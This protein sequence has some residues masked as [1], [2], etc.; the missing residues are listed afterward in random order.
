MGPLIF[1][2]PVLRDP[3]PL[4]SRLAVRMVSQPVPGELIRWQVSTQCKIVT[5]RAAE[6]VFGIDNR[7][8]RAVRRQAKNI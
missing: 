4:T 3:N 8:R 2:R 5:L 1:A 7:S 6:W